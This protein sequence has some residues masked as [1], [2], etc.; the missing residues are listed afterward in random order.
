MFPLFLFLYWSYF[1]CLHPLHVLLW[2]SF[3]FAFS[4][5]CMYFCAPIIL[6]QLQVDLGAKPSSNSCHFHTTM[7]VQF[8]NSLSNMSTLCSLVYSLP[9]PK[10]DTATCY[11]YFDSQGSEFLSLNH[12]SL[13]SSEIQCLLGM[14]NIK[15]MFY[16]LLL[17]KT[18]SN[19]GKFL[20]YV[21]Q[22]T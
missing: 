11:G 8:R 19:V 1:C 14:E 5:F 17:C 16:D 12:S 7:L 3:I 10:S 9:R 20:S 2:I 22:S 4:V 13:D 6:L 21:R 15:I 18:G